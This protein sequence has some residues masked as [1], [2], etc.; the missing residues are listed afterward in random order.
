M[1]NYITTIERYVL[2]SLQK[3]EKTLFDLVLDTKLEPK[4]L[5]SIL[6]KIPGC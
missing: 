3:S 1:D 2:E 4:V 5:K 6:F